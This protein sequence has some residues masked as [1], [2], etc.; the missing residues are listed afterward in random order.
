M[1]WTLQH[2]LTPNLVHLF[3][4]HQKT[5]VAGTLTVHAEPLA[6]NALPRTFKSQ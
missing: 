3:S 2:H 6:T 1:T 4:T 5:V